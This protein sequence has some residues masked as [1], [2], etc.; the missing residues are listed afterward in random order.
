MTE[1]VEQDAF[2]PPPRKKGCARVLLVTLG[3]IFVVSCLGCGVLSYFLFQPGKPVPPI[4]FVDEHTAGMIVV[5]LDIDDPETKELAKYAIEAGIKRAQDDDTASEM[6]DQ[7]E[8]IAAPV[9]L[10]AS[11]KVNPDGAVNT[12]GS[13]VFSEWHGTIRWAARLWF[14]GIRSDDTVEAHQYRGAWIVDG[15]KLTPEN[16][17]S[18]PGGANLFQNRLFSL[19]DSCLFIGNSE[20]DVE[21]AV[22]AYTSKPVDI[23][24]DT[25]FLNAWRETNQ[26]TL[27]YGVLLND[28]NNSAIAAFF[29]EDRADKAREDL[30][31]ILLLDPSQITMTSF[32]L[33][34]MPED[35]AELKLIV[36]TTSENAARQV[37]ISVESFD[38]S[39]YAQDIPLLF[40]TV[41]SQITG[42]TYKSTIHITGIRAIIDQFISGK[43]QAEELEEGEPEDML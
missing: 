20:N 9:T 3:V 5:R 34:L 38:R 23:E 24:A 43:L 13:L 37:Q 29:P 30:Q 40:E 18:A 32:S 2:S 11:Y 16:L 1:Q 41:S 25:P 7:L 36:Q 39:E 31:D 33:D 21:K 6:Q 42:T 28:D 27:A 14:W 35:K 8:H 19:L 22:D 26:N 17:K 10:L 15:S 4:T 12:F